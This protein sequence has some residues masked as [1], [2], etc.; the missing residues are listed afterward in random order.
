MPKVAKTAL[1]AGVNMLSRRDHAALELRRKLAE[2]HYPKAEVEAAMSALAA[3]G[4]VD[5]ARFA[6]SRAG[7]R[8]RQS[9]WGWAKIAMELRG[10][11]I[12]DT[13]IAA[14][15]AALA[16][17]GVDF[18]E[19]AARLAR[20]VPEGDRKARDKAIARLVRKGYSL[21]EARNAVDAADAVA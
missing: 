14:A 3:K 5:D 7:Y 12:A 11:G 19:H 16:A 2:K 15:K 1:Q 21:D 20:R 18:A 4:Y 10:V 8:A 13:D 17:E 6:V 9:R